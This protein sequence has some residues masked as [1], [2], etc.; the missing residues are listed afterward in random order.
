MATMTVESRR[1]YISTTY[2]ESCVPALKALGAKWDAERHAWWVGSAKRAQV[3]QILSAADQEPAAA[4]TEEPDSA[5]VLARVEYRG[6]SYFVLAES[7]EKNRCKICKLSG[8][9]GQWVDMSECSLVRTYE[10]RE[11]KG[12]Y[13]R[14]TGRMVYTTLGSMRR[15]VEKQRGAEARGEPACA[16]CGKRGHLTH[17]MEDGL[18]KCRSCCDMPAD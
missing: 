9:I 11:E 3:E 16:S 12:A 8:S 10:P 6:Q 14:S 5:R 13:G 2:G 15:F 18:L 7:I 1:V 17:D 4:Q